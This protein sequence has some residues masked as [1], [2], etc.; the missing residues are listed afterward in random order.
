MDKANFL[1]P[2]ITKCTVRDASSIKILAGSVDLFSGDM[3]EWEVD[4][5]WINE[6]C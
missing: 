2:G 4:E 1:S 6:F 3:A 5:V